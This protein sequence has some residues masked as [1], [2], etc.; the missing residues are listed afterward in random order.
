VD[1]A[2]L[3]SLLNYFLHACLLSVRML[4][5]VVPL[6]SL[7]AAPAMKVF[8]GP[9]LEMSSFQDKW[10]MDAA[11]APYVP[12]PTGFDASRFPDRS[13]EGKGFQYGDSELAITPMG[14]D[15]SRFPDRS[16]EGVNYQ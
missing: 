2:R 14:A 7:A 3:S 9:Q 5:Q 13:G 1:H 10:D 15:G 8:T 16:G 12:S 11:Y 4:F 6:H